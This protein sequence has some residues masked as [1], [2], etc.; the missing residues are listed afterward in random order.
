MKKSLL[1]FARTVLCVL[2]GTKHITNLPESEVAV[3]NTGQRYTR[4]DVIS[5]MLVISVLSKRIATRMQMADEEGGGD[6][7]KDER[8][9]PNFG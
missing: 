6:H 2:E 5:L 8:L 1:T 3:M 7:V 4:A 9:I